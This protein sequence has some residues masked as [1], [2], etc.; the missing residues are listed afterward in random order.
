MIR[1]RNK[2]VK[3]VGI[4]DAPYQVVQRDGTYCPFYRTWQN[5]L[6]RCYCKSYLNSKPSYIGC[7]VCEEWKT[8]STFSRW[9]E[10]QRWQGFQLDK[11]LLE[12]GNKC[13][14]PEFCVFIPPE[15]NSFLKDRKNDRGDLP[16]G[17][18]VKGNRYNSRCGNPL[19]GGR[20][21]LGGF[22]CPELAHEAWRCR[23]RDIGRDICLEHNL[24]QTVTEAVENFYK[25]S[26]FR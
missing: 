26:L 2:L 6:T 10:T 22:D 1:N 14:C 4:N 5:M 11:D 12:H 18:T 24:P 15:L 19:T 3:G 9:M 13:Y 8:F 20:E 21:F 25:N 7:Y 23:K 17:V 16:L